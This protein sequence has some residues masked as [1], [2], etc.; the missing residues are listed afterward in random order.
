[1]EVAE[2]AH[3]IQLKPICPEQEAIPAPK[4]VE[5]LHRGTSLHIHTSVCCIKVFMV[6]FYEVCVQEAT[7]LSMVIYMSLLFFPTFFS[8]GQDETEPFKILFTM[9][10]RIHK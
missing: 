7:D 1:M 8:L 10:R 9:L 2:Y 3:M 4:S 6:R 5:P